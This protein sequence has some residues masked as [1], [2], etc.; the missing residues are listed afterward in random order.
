MCGRYRTKL[1]APEHAFAHLRVPIQLPLLK[2]L[3]GPPDEDV[4]PA[5]LRPVLTNAAPREVD[6]LTWGLLPAWHKPD[7]RAQINARSESIFD[8]PF[9]RDAARDHRCVVAVTGYYEWSGPPGKKLKHLFVPTDDD[10]LILAGLFVPATRTFSLLTCDP[11]EVAARVHDRM[12]V[13]LN[14]GDALDR[15]LAPSRMEARDLADLLVACPNERLV[16]TPP[17]AAAS[18]QGSL[19]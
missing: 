6:R 18:A 4:R 5:T 3:L 19:F 13:I 14:D 11:N 10:V 16:A 9:F 7:T 12:P 8:K 17:A 2:E 15:W 1:D